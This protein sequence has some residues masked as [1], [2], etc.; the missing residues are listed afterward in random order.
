[1]SLVQLRTTQ[2]PFCTTWQ[3]HSKVF[4]AVPMA[5]TS[6][7]Q[8]NVTLSIEIRLIFLFYAFVWTHL[9]VAMASLLVLDVCGLCT[10]KWLKPLGSIWFNAKVVEEEAVQSCP[11]YYKTFFT[12][13][14]KLVCFFFE[15]SHDRLIF[16]INEEHCQATKLTAK[17]RVC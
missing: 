16:A 14:N 17:F 5:W 4:R 1:M 2:K 11:Q 15:K 6:I 8:T 12:V 3:C 9:N 7:T 10:N 13:S